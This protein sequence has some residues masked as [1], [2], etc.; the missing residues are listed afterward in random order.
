MEKH[1][2]LNSSDSSSFHW[3]SQWDDDTKGTS[4]EQGFY[5]IYC[6]PPLPYRSDL[7][8]AGRG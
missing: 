3:R 5:T 8:A 4:C 2:Q 1:K 6:L 7:A